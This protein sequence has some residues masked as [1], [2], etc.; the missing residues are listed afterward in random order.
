MVE[1]DHCADSLGDVDRRRRL[2]ELGDGGLDAALGRSVE[3]ARA[4][5]DLKAFY[6]RTAET[7]FRTIRDALR[8][9]PGVV[10]YLSEQIAHDKLHF[11]VRSPELRDIR[12]RLAAEQKQRARLAIGATLFVSGT[13]VLTLA[14]VTWPGWLLLVAGAGTLLAGRS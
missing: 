6:T 1:V 11:D 10:R 2:H 14:S 7:Y 9:L 5:V 13:L 3:R 12:D 8:E 4:D